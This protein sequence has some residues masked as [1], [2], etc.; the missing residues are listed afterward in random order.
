MKLIQGLKKSI[1]FKVRNLKVLGDSELIVR[2]IRNTI[3]CVS[4]NLKGFRTKVWDLI[5][6]FNAFNINSIPRLQNAASDLLATFATRLVPTNNKC[7]IE[8][9]FRPS[10]P[11]NVTNLRVFDDDQQILE[12]LT[13]DEN[14]KDSVIDD[15]E[16]QANIQSRN[17]MP[18][19]VTTLE[20][21]FDLNNKFRRPTNVKT[22]SSS[23]QCKL[24]HLGTEVEPKY[25]NLGK[26]CSPGERCKFIIL[27]Q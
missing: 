22:N 24:I 8:L 26:C 5:T 27:F 16:H 18:K 9:I 20:G 19:G 2:K 14:F 7:S 3:H 1:E 11:H 17:F 4:P 15:E 10:I 21:L 25:V 13:N 23:M 12:F 6:N